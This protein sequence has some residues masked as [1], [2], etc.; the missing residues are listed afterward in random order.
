MLKKIDICY[1]GYNLE[2]FFLIYQ[3]SNFKINAVLEIDFST[4]NTTNPF[5]YL[6]KLIYFLR[7]KEQTN[8]FEKISLFFWR[9]FFIFFSSGIYKKYSKYLIFISKK[10]IKILD[11]KNKSSV[12]FLEKQDILIV[13]TWEIL[14]ENIVLSPKYGT[15]NIHPSKLPKYAGALP[16]LWALKNKDEITAVTYMLI[17]REMDTGAII[18]Q[19]RINIDIFDDCL[20]LERKI[21]SVVEATLIK[22][23]E[24][25]I[26][27]DIRL[28]NQ[29][30]ATRTVT[31]KY[32]E[33]KKILWK[34]ENAKEIYNK[35]NLYP[36]LIPQEYCYFILNNKKV[37]LRN[38]QI[39]CNC[40]K[41]DSLYGIIFYINTKVGCVKFVLFRD[42]S[43]TDSLLLL[44]FK[45]KI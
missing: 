36:Y 23:I 32:E 22:D 45:F 17:N 35:V 5:N 3:R 11:I 9:Y 26:K 42:I 20:S 24:G 30:P 13:D 43:F 2:T 4:F 41:K 28:K 38:I 18:N 14:P 37:Y 10:N 39:C 25:Y 12:S 44:F 34:T 8:F 7:K 6:F 1:A 33:Y 19:H 40:N 21:K 29:D 31:A 15:F 16:T 27:G